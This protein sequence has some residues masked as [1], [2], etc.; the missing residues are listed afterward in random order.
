MRWASK[1]EFLPRNNLVRRI[2]DKC[3]FKIQKLSTQT[4]FSEVPITT[5]QFFFN[6]FF[7]KLGVEKIALHVGVFL[8]V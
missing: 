2:G 5:K 3:V 1:M 7:Q 6:T 4:F 8:K